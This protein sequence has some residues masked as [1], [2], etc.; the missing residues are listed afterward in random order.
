MHFKGVDSSSNQKYDVTLNFFS[1]IN[2]EKILTKNNS[3]VYEFV[4]YKKQESAEYWPKLT[5][6]KNKLHFLKVDFNKWKNEGSDDENE[7]GGAGFDN[8][9]LFSKLNSMDGSNKPSFD[10]F[11]DEEDSDDEDL[12]KLSS[13]QDDEEE[14]KTE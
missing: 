8:L 12:P 14:K 7:G 5:N 13:E 11:E 4:I 3:R 6:D 9:D 1:K 10:D 2:P